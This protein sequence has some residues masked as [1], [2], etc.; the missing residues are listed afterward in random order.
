MKN[1]LI[2]GLNSFV[3]NS[4]VDYVK[5][6]SDMY[7]VDKVS[8]RDDKWR[9]L[10]LS[11]Y[12]VIFHVAGIAHAD[13]EN[14]D[15]LTKKKYYQVNRDLTKEIAAKYKSERGNKSSLF[16]YMSSIIVYGENYGVRNERIINRSTIPNPS[17]FYG[18]S[19]LQAEYALYELE[20]ID[21][22]IAV[23]RAPM[24]IGRESKGNYQTLVKIAQKTLFFPNF[25]NKRS[26]I[27]IDNLNSEIL[28]I[29][30][31][32][33]SGIFFPQEG[34]YICTSLLVKQ[35]GASFG[36]KIYL[37]SG[38]NWLIV[39]LSYLPG[40]LGKMINKAFGSLVYSK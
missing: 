37:I 31:K 13:I 33:N 27:R 11:V 23:I 17:N 3:G 24:I 10:D 21:F 25:K 32:E 39:L 29:I 15:D 2:T 30:E 40:K 9:G 6:Y 36:K 26:M 19:K 20:S 16:I 8:L 34:E 18:D 35:I 12:D 7:I 4:F 38:F 14:V 5:K 22:K 1:L 28:Q